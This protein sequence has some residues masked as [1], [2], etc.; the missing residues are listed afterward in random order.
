MFYLKGDDEQHRLTLTH[1]GYRYYDFISLPQIED[2][3]TFQKINYNN[4]RTIIET[5]N[6]FIQSEVVT[7]KVIKLEDLSML[8]EKAIKQKYY[9]LTKKISD[10]K[11]KDMTTYCTT[12][13]KSSNIFHN[14]YIV[15]KGGKYEGNRNTFKKITW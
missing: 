2:R 8:Q 11:R 9:V 6:A 7:P 1:K 3:E 12:Q 10:I 13:I 14:N 15:D 4:C 5:L